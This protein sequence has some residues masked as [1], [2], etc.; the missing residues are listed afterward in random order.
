MIKK[1]QLAHNE[2]IADLWNEAFGDKKADVFGYLKFLLRYFYVYEENGAVLAMAAVLPLTFKENRGGYIYAVATK[3]EMQGKGISTQLINYIK[4]IPEFDFF[5]L[6]PQSES[7]F[8]FYKRF[9]FVPI[10]CIETMTIPLQ[11]ITCDNICCTPLQIQEYIDFRKEFFDGEL[12]AWDAEAMRFAKDMYGG[13]F[14]QV[15]QNETQIG[16]C[17][18]F[19]NGDHLIIKELLTKDAELAGKIASYFCAKKCTISYVKFGKKPS[20]MVY[21]ADFDKQYFN[22]ALD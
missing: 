9:D 15:T 10:S 14:Y 3:K 16:A 12:I 21:P 22:I 1:A 20:A 8:N 6:V 5:V 19:K 18:C 13:D 7:L 11:N 4:N 2:Q 17:F